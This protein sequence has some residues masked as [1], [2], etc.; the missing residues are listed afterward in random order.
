MLMRTPLRWLCV[1][2]LLVLAAAP[3]WAADSDP[4]PI[5]SDVTVKRLPN[6]LT[7][8]IRANRKPENRAQFHLVINAGSILETE[9]QLGLAHF[10]EHMAFNGTK[11]FQKHEL[12]NFL[13]RIGMQFGA[14]LNAYTSFDETA[15]RLEIPMDN[16]EVLKKTFQILEDWAHQITFDAREIEKERGVVVEEWRT[17]RGVAGR[18]RDKQ[19]PV[20]F[21]QSLYAERLPIGKTN[22]IQ[23]ADRE[24][25]LDF[26]RKWYRPDL[27]A[28]VAVGD[29]DRKKIEAL[30]I[31]HFGKLKNPP[32]SPRRPAPLVPD[33]SDTLFSIETDPELSTTTVQVACK[34]PILSEGT[35]LD[36]RRD[37]VNSLYSGMLNQRLSE[38]VQE[39]NPP[40]S[41]AG[42]GRSRMVRVKD[43]VMQRAAVKEGLFAEGL[44][45]LLVESRRARRDGFTSAELE[46]S[47]KQMLRGIETAYEE[48]DKTDSGSYAR[49]YVSNFLEGEAIPGI[50]EEV[51][52][53]RRFLAEI[54]IDEV[55]R[56][57]DGWITESNRIILFNAPEK[58]G[59]KRPTREDILAVI[60][61]AEGTDITAYQD[62]VSDGPLL[63][64]PPAA[65]KVVSEKQHK[66]VDATEWVLSNGIH[67]I[68]K[69]TTNQN[70]QILMRAFSP[71]GHSLVADKD[72]LSGAMAASIVSQSGFGAYD[73]IQ[74]RKKLS[75]KMVSVGA[76][77]D[78]LFEN[79]QGSGSP[80][81]LEIWF[82]LMHLYFTAPRAD[83]KAFQSL[84]TRMK[85]GLENRD[86]NPQAVFGDAIEKALYGDHYRH[87]PMSLDL[88]KE[89][90]REAA[91]R[92]YRER[93]ANAGDFTFVFVGAFKPDELRPLIQTYLASLPHSDRTERGRDVG[94]DP[95]RGRLEVEVKKGIEPK[96]SVRLTFHGG[97]RWSMEERFALRS[98]VDILRIRLRE[99]LREDKGGVYGVG[100][101]GDLSRLPKETYSCGVSFTCS[102]DNVA[103]LTQATLEEIKRLQT[104]GP[105]TENLEKVRETHLRN[106]EKGLKEDSFW[107]G[108]LTFY[109]EHELPFVGIMKLPERAQALTAKRVQDAA[110]KYFSPENLLIARLLP[111]PAE[112]A[113]AKE[114][115]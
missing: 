19:I 90:D 29:F 106:Y 3:I 2:A 105:S 12:V 67:V 114:T 18:L 61:E 38:R 41:Y 80:K 15:Y 42:I 111:E 93:F 94:D 91:L 48:R 39:A 6:G 104:D 49:E 107:L 82:Q 44:K 46:R 28:V 32:N 33:H 101:Y 40:Y 43:L 103:D 22:V 9:K 17:G 55:N 89:L 79:V 72:Y 77:I 63:A 16:A 110:Q 21:H 102:P 30:I 59:L 70:D 85:V 64:T 81:D 78:E 57:G 100:V 83:E 73:S 109:R 13:E 115:R 108:N 76:S 31:E 113:S 92:I 71:G 74:L 5:D 112:S 99:L 4:L 50:V 58:P 51:R 34:H 75:G 56:A 54:T 53:T 65:G 23:T 35:A 95:K 68:L 66:E 25:F 84:V 87:R 62:G 86:R 36:Y 98:A 20:I 96:S 47:K 10:L 14:D 26:Y 97:A 69:P 8:Y 27:M 88:L 24:E 11:N 7:Y 37:L 60:K 52:L 45:A 1:L